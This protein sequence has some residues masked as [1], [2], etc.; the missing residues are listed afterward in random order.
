[1]LCARKF[2]TGT[3]SVKHNIVVRDARMIAAMLPH[4][5]IFH[6]LGTCSFVPNQQP[7][8][9]R[10]VPELLLSHAQACSKHVCMLRVF[11]HSSLRWCSYWG[12]QETAH[13]LYLLYGVLQNQPFSGILT[14]NASCMPFQPPYSTYY[15]WIT[16]L[17]MPKPQADIGCSKWIELV[18]GHVGLHNGIIR[19]P[20]EG[21]KRSRGCGHIHR[22]F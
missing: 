11:F 19:P 10:C 7:S 8:P 20:D 9:L 6:G 15:W 18:V 2:H 17:P 5:Y 12:F 14:S 13:D 21:R 1:M 3:L 16:K 22:R 4:Y